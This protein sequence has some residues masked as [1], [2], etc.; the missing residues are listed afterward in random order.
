MNNRLTLPDLAGIL[1]ETMGKDRADM[2]QFLREFVMVVSENVCKDK[3]VKVKGLG[4]FKVIRVEERESVN[5]NTGERFIIPAHYKFS[6]LPDRELKEQ[7]N[8]P[9]SFFETTELNEDVDFSDME[10]SEDPEKKENE[11]DESVEDVMEEKI[12]IIPSLEQKEPEKGKAIENNETHKIVKEV[13][14]KTFGEER[15][16]TDITDKSVKNK[17][18][19]LPPES[20]VE[21]V[22]KI[23]EPVSEPFIVPPTKVNP[24]K[25]KNRLKW[26][27]G[28]V[29]IVLLMIGV[30]VGLYLNKNFFYKSALSDTEPA[31]LESEVQPVDSIAVAVPVSV[32]DTAAVLAAG[33]VDVR[34][35]PAQPEQETPKILGKVKIEAG[36]RL[37]LISLEYYGSKLF[38]VYIYEF[39]KSIIKDPNNV[40]IGTELEIPAPEIYGIDAH[41][42]ASLEK[43]AARQTEILSGEL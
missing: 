19:S 37:T 43:A 5:V 22:E 3:I 38:W 29:A 13:E 33:S 18:L 36:S 40:P 20:I 31:G 17:D 30:N 34:S 16:N 41:S 21:P 26:I 11:E 15:K 42:R 2:E 27:V 14:S 35:E 28:S 32:P 8:K 25:R 39:N 23:T 6:F 24:R 1:T 12:V 4:A 10:I 7:V 9:F